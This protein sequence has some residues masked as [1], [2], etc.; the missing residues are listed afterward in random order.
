ML[1]HSSYSNKYLEKNN[2]PAVH[3]KQNISVEVS[4]M[5]FKI[6][7]MN[8][9]VTRICCRCFISFLSMLFLLCECKRMYGFSYWCTTSRLVTIEFS[10]LKL[11]VHRISLGR[12]RVLLTCS[13]FISRNIRVFTQLSLGV[14]SED[15]KYKL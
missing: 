5:R 8:K 4:L 10:H 3:Q 9:R 15:E 12:S 6:G 7:S 1:L 13:V 2:L 11:F 14:M